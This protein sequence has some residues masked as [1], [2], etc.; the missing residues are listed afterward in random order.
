MTPDEL[1]QASADLAAV[2]AAID[3]LVEE[4]RSDAELFRALAGGSTDGRKYTRDDMIAQHG[5]EKVEFAIHKALTL[6]ACV[7][8]RH[9][10]NRIILDQS[11]AE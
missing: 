7:L 6:A 8:S 11:L 5:R 9:Q 1:R 4:L 10:M 3:Q 2:D